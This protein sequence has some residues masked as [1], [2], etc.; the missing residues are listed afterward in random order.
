[1][2]L[3]QY[4]GRFPLENKNSIES[5][6]PLGKLKLVLMQLLSN[7]INTAALINKFQEYLLYDDVL[8]YTWKVLPQLT[9]KCNPNDVYIMN[10]LV[11]LEKLKIM[12]N[13]ETQLLCYS[14]GKSVVGVS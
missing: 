7:K 14:E 6:V 4:E 10:Y 12:R 2:S 5:Y 11:L 9:A 1:M 13:K 3:L 8:F